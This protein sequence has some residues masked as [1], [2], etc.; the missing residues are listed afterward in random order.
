MVTIEQIKDVLQEE[1]EILYK[2]GI[3]RVG[4]FGSYI[5]GEAKP[6]SDIDIL[7]DVASDSSLTLF[8]RVEI[9]Q[10]LSEKLN[11]KIDIAIK[12]DLNLYIVKEFSP[13]LYMSAKDVWVYI[14]DIINTLSLK[15]IDLIIQ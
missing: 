11:N 10:R 3:E 6:D 2:L 14:S 4:I 13:G 12:A 8:S 1:K 9:E 5:R 15:K 7:I